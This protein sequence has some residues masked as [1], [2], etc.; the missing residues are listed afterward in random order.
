MRNGFL[1]LFTVAA[2][3]G[4]GGSD[5]P[6]PADVQQQKV[7]CG[8]LG[9]AQL[10]AAGT[11]PMEIT[12]RAVVAAT[13]QVPEHCRI[14]G[15]LR[16]EAGSSI[17]FAVNVPTSGWNGKFLVLGNGGY[18][19]EAP[20][21]AGVELASGYATASTDGGHPA[22]EGARAFFNDRV[23]EIDYGYR[24]IHLTTVA[25]KQITKA[26]AGRQPERAY[27]NG[28]STG[29][30]QALMAAQ[31]YPEDF[32]GI[33]AGAPALNLTGLAI[34][35]NW[36]LRQFQKNNFAGNIFGKTTLLADAVKTA[37]ADPADP[38]RLI[39]RPERCSFD[40]ATLQCAPGQDPATCF[41]ADQ[42]AA[43]KAVYE[44]PKTTWG[45]QWYPG[46]PLGSEPSWASWIV[47]DS[48]DPARWSPLQ[49]GFGFSFVNNL[50][51][52][53]DPPQ[54]YQWTDFN[55]DTDPYQRAFMSKILDAINPDL[56]PLSA[57]QA[58]LLIY[59]G[60]GDGLIGYQPTLD[61]FQ[62]V[63][64][65]VG[66]GRTREFARLFL[67]PGMD[68]CDGFPRGGVSVANATWLKTLEDWVE[69][70]QAPESVAGRQHPRDTTAFTRPVCAW[71]QAATYK[72][73]GDRLDA[74]SYTCQ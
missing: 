64:G 6:P 1:S 19:G 50:F 52:E 2:I 62:Q 12:G 17:A 4:C 30:R 20:R 32:D 54:T 72:G 55:F 10:D 56:T 9:P 37:C 22:S 25:G 40:V 18:A 11:G 46:K 21:A 27:F 33:I 73:S 69:K 57:R 74:A 58:K 28:C 34:E 60:T 49:G 36:S 45:R 67:V 65:T 39:V 3:A 53:T 38:L 7:A 24:A 51:F 43:V 15:V 48:S 23:A 42:V 29:G 14:E 13:A 59:H 63:Q 41:T 70:G 26:L 8:D 44:G 66:T 61:Y 31:R 71:P 47:A 35:Q 68:H 5:G 16:P